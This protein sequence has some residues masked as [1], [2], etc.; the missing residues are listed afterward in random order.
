MEGRIRRMRVARASAERYTPTFM[1][2][3]IAVVIRR[4][5]GSHVGHMFDVCSGRVNI[6]FTITANMVTSMEPCLL[7]QCSS[8]V[9]RWH[10][11]GLPPRRRCRLASRRDGLRCFSYASC[12][13]LFWYWRL[14][15]AALIRLCSP[16]RPMLPSI[17]AASSASA[18]HACR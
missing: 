10:E 2:I 4:C 1:P 16:P 3:T 7:V 11:K 14:A 15:H 18:I 6:Q 8:N 13:R 9:T 17:G 12:W 5:N